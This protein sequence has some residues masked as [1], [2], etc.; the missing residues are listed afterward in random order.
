MTMYA[1]NTNLIAQNCEV[2]A[3]ETALFKGHFEMQPMIFVLESMQRRTLKFN[4]LSKQLVVHGATTLA[5]IEFCYGFI[6][7]SADYVSST[8]KMQMVYGRGDK[9]TST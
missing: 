4:D 1:N 2:D 3:N 9:K 5:L 6:V 7:T 8:K